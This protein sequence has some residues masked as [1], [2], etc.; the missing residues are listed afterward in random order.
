MAPTLP[1]RMGRLPV[2]VGWTRRVTVARSGYPFRAS[3]TPFGGAPMAP[4]SKAGLK[5]GGTLPLTVDLPRIRIQMLILWTHPFR[6]R[7]WRS[8]AGSLRSRLAA[9]RASRSREVARIAVID[10]PPPPAAPGPAP[11]PTAVREPPLQRRF[12]FVDLDPTQCGNPACRVPSVNGRHAGP[13][14]FPAPPPRR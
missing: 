4:C 12:D 11:D 8:G 1:T 6:L 3:V 9:I 14:V 13:C 10:T 7:L 2:F 5:P